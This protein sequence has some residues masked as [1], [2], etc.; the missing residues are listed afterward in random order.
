MSLTL[1]PVSVVS[2]KG[3]G[4]GPSADYVPIV[5]HHNWFMRSGG[6][7]VADLWLMET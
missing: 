4:L 1:L 3:S 2:T 7:A 6:P 5:G